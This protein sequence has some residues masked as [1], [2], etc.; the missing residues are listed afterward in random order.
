[1]TEQKIVWIGGYPFVEGV[2]TPPPKDKLEQEIIG[3]IEWENE[4]KAKGVC[5]WELA[6]AFIKRLTQKE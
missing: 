1:M 2:N 5:G 6:Q 4:M 3:D